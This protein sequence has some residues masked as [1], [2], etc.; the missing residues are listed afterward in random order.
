MQKTIP[1]IDYQILFKKK[2]YASAIF[3]L[4]QSSEKALKSLSYA[5]LEYNLKNVSHNTTNII[6][7]FRKRY[8]IIHKLFSL[9]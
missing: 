3:H 4:Q 5:V 6:K 1:L 2:H 9:T 8:T 7:E